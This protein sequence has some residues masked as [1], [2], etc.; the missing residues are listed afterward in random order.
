MNP[1]RPRVYVIVLNWNNYE[2]S[3]ECIESLERA[4]YPEQRVMVVDNGS[5]DGSGA[6]LKER[7]PQ[8]LFVFND[9][10]LGF[11]RG[12]NAGIR[13][14]MED[15]QCAYIVLLNN[16]ATVEPNFIE[17]TVD[18][19]ES[20][21][22]IGAVSGKVLMR[23]RKLWYAG[24]DID[25]LRGRA[26]TRGFGELDN[27][28]YDQVIDVKFVTGGFMFIRRAAIQ[29]VGALPEEYFFGVEE[30]DYSMALRKAGFRLCYQPASVAHHAGDGSHD[31]W[32]PKFV[33]NYYRNKLIFQRKY[34]PPGLFPLWKQV[35]KWYARRSGEKD[36]QR[37]KAFA[38]ANLNLSVT[39]PPAEW[40]EFALTEAY[41]DDAA[42]AP[43]DENSMKDFAKKF[44][45][46]KAAAPAR[47]S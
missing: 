18:L 47:T 46:R 17:P 39:I 7:F 45:A 11:A 34:L 10:N 15:P 1:P 44:E 38:E 42:R 13:R 32:D 20:D 3:A 43:L 30:W 29:K 33:Y 19:M 40:F 28:Q 23:D 27:G 24:G 41:R 26:R 2:D 9:A 31:N 4:T 6:K 8:H 12:C 25:L 14:A 21:P 35:F 37:W 36:R 16:D 22:R 5:K